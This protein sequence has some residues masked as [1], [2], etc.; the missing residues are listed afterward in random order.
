[1]S[2]DEQNPKRRVAHNNHRALDPEG[3]DLHARVEK[4]QGEE[5]EG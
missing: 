4:I 5:E 2:R 1:M 3:L